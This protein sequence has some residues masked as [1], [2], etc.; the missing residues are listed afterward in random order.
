MKREMLIIFVFGLFVYLITNVLAV[1]PATIPEP[2]ENMLKCSDS[3]GGI[4]GTVQGA[5]I[6]YSGGQP[7]SNTDYC[8]SSI[9]V[10]E[11]W[12]DGSAAQSIVLYCAQNETTQCVN[13]ACV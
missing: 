2:E 7:Y 3:D 11:Y 8:F 4:I 12:C 5:V 1:P 6:G 9:Q 13:G 10:N